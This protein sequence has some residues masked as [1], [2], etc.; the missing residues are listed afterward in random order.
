MLKGDSIYYKDMNTEIFNN[1]RILFVC[2]E[3]YS[4]PLLFL[5]KKWLKNNQVAAFFFNPCETK[6]AKCT[7]NEITYYAYKELV[8][9][10]LFTSDDIADEFTSI[11]HREKVCDP[12]YLEKIEREYTHFQNVNNQIMATQ[13]LTRHYH[14]R[15]YMHN[16]TY[17]QQLNWLILNYKN[18]VN[19]I[20]E[21]K[22]D[23]VLDT[24]NA[25]LARTVLR[26]VCFKEG[27]PYI[28]LDHPRYEMYKLYSYNLDLHYS[29]LFKETFNKLSQSEDVKLNEGLAYVERFRNKPTIMHSMYKNDVTAQYKPTPIFLSIRHVIGMAKYF[30]DQDRVGSNKKIKDANPLLYPNS[31]EYIKFYFSF[32]M[33]K[34]R[35]MRKNKFFSAPEDVKY[36]YMPLHLI[37]ESTTFSISPMYVNEFDIIAAVSKSLPAGWWLYVKE[38]QAMVGERGTDFYEKVNKLP[39]VRMVQLNY[40]QDPKPWITNSQ[41]V[42]T[43]SGTSAYE[44]ALLGKHSIVFADTSFSLIDGVERVRSFEDLPA[45]LSRFIDPVDNIKSCA[46]Y[47][48]AVKQMGYSINLKQLLND[49]ELILRGRKEIDETYQANLD[50]L[51]SLFIE[52]FEKFRNSAD[53]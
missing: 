15:N 52:G 41:G 36:V 25:E 8:G 45:A 40:Y 21:Y 42:V 13:F 9:I 22:P 5:A 30:I 7:L 49:G 17:S 6:Y 2:K 14:Y 34:Q 11:L 44:A 23:V 48:E 18:V 39:N 53:D 3:T 24:D 12:D 46:A 16:C 19:I 27:I 47:I 20:G 37:P 35:L 51:E 10:R 32:E 50:N 26:E 28:T 1:K 38:H 43:I 33:K 31:W 4:Y 29:E